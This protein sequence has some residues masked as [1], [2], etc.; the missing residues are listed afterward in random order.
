MI[1]G[2]VVLKIN[3]NGSFSVLVAPD[4]AKTRGYVLAP[5]VEEAFRSA[6]S[7]EFQVFLGAVKSSLRVKPNKTVEIWKQLFPSLVTELKALLR[8][9]KYRT[10]ISD[11]V[12]EKAFG[13]LK[14]YPVIQNE[15]TKYEIVLPFKAYRDTE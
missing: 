2:N 9:E 5:T 4:Q 10:E 15:K 14:H 6:D 3:T 8:P 13:L 12:G 1:F 7:D 11:E